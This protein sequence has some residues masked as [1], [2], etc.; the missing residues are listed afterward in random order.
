[1]ANN[2]FC[3]T[4]KS[5]SKESF[6]GYEFECGDYSIE[7]SKRIRARATKLSNVLQKNLIQVIPDV[8][9]KVR[10]RSEN[11]DDIATFKSPLETRGM[12]ECKPFAA[13]TLKSPKVT[14]R[15][16]HTFN[17]EMNLALCLP[18]FLPT[19]LRRLKTEKGFLNRWKSTGFNGWFIN[20]VMIASAQKQI[21]NL[22][23]N[24][25]YA[26]PDQK[27]SQMDGVKKILVNLSQGYLPEVVRI[28]LPT[29]VAGDYL[30]LAVG[31]Q[32]ASIPF[33][34]DHAT[35]VA[36]AV[37]WLNSL[38]NTWSDEPMYSITTN[39]TTTIWVTEK[40]TNA[41]VYVM[42]FRDTNA[43][44]NWQDQ[45]AT[46]GGDVICEV[47]QKSENAHTPIQ[48]DFGKITK[49]NF[50]E[51]RLTAAATLEGEFDRI[52]GVSASDLVWCVS[53][54]FE[55][56]MKIAMG[57][58]FKCCEGNAMLSE[59]LGMKIC[60]LSQL[61][62]SEYFATWERNIQ[63]G[64]DLV[65][66]FSTVST[67]Y[68]WDCQTVKF[69]MEAAAG[70]DILYPSEV[71]TNLDCF[72]S[73]FQAPAPKLASQMCVSDCPTNPCFDNCEA[74]FTWEVHVDEGSDTSKIVVTNTGNCPTSSTIS[75]E[76]S[77]SE[78][79]G[80]SI[81]YTLNAADGEFN[82]AGANTLDGLNASVIQ[83]VST[84]DGCPDKDIIKADTIN[85]SEDAIEA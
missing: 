75:Y 83:T 33:N 57:H 32:T 79:A 23:I 17:M 46:C 26:S 55:R 25:D 29:L 15:W 43:T 19:F 73:N 10:M 47:V 38:Q 11:Y 61:K 56:M 4:P 12:H 30:H 68:D 65:S 16:L 8:V 50:Y 24:G 66:D 74:G 5:C 59:V 42:A 53:P 31:G 60:V 54:E 13:Q 7:D 28:T 82:F 80:G 18:K 3:P 52:E 69:R 21:Q 76:L 40:N 81:Q 2:T 37:T 1:M 70:I 64:T 67:K 6:N 71:I 84:T 9:D 58:E 20:D 85:L 72:P 36:D 44:I 39:G 14:D 78:E 35:T 45:S 62:G 77:L 49:D 51:W 41:G 27:L 34:T 22:I 63:F 48:D